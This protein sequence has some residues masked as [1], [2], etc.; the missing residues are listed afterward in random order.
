MIRSLRFCVLLVLTLSA[1]SCLQPPSKSDTHGPE[2]PVEQ[3]QEAI[4]KAWDDAEFHSVQQG[5]Y[6]YIE[7]DQKISN[8]EP[9]VVYKEGTQV[10]ERKLT[11]TT[12]DYKMLIRSTSLKDGVFEPVTSLEDNISIDRPSE[13]QSQSYPAHLNPAFA[14]ALRSFE[15]NIEAAGENQMPTSVEALQKSMQDGTVGVRSGQGR[16]H[17]LGIVAVNNML[18]ACVKED[19]WDVTCHNLQVS[20][21][22]RSAPTGVSSKPDCGGIPNCEIRY[23]K[24]SFD[25]VL[26]VP[27]VDDKPAR[28][29]K[30]IYDMVFSP[31]VPF[32]SRLMDFC[33]QGMVPAGTQK[34]LI[35]L[36]NRVQYFEPGVAPAPFTEN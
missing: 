12:I 15:N 28:E 33:Y 4:L 5:E 29:E 30:V 2:V 7:Q 18:G 34:V 13:L 31:D 8:L 14:P 22:V 36:C 25:L 9:R 21:G 3:V 24:V 10:L 1:T 27:A 20:E 23:K 19:G 16:N 35:K 26:K 32:L 11:E 17:F 6:L